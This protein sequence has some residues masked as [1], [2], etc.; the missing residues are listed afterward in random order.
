MKR[1]IM[2]K[3]KAFTLLE[4]TVALV[5]IGVLSVMMLKAISVKEFNVKSSYAK[6][7]KA[8]ETFN[9]A[10]QNI[11]LEDTKRCPDRSMIADAAG[12]YYKTLLYCSTPEEPEEGEELTETCNPVSTSQQVMDIYGDFVKY[13]TKN[14]DFCANS[15][16][17]VDNL[18]GAKIAGDIY[19]AIEPLSSVSDCPSYFHPG[20]SEQTTPE[21]KCWAKLYVDTNGN[22][23][24]NELGQ[25]IFVFPMDGEGVIY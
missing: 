13:V 25:D 23:A 7:F 1:G 16:C 11:R 14:L 19:V 10:S 6:A 21:G 15:A 12:T 8:A 4:L 9:I 5:I 20:D 3:K 17:D 24:P 2:D 18:V 22:A